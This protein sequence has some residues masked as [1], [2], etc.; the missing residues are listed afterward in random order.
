MNAISDSEFRQKLRSYMRQV[1]DDSESLIVTTKDAD[2]TVVVMGKKDYDA[3]QETLYILSNQ[4]L[5]AQI[6][7][8]QAEFTNGKAQVHDLKDLPDD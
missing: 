4:A 6:R 2:D 7:E 5:V 1:N 3:M 8:G